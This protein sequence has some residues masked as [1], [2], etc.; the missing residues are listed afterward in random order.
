[1]I[2]AKVYVLMTIVVSCLQI[3]VTL[4]RFDEP[5]PGKRYGGQDILTSVIAIGMAIALAYST[6]CFK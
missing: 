3:G 2:F 5:K 1:M 6:G 4:G